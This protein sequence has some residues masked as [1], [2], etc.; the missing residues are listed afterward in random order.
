MSKSLTAFKPSRMTV[1]GSE[2]F[3]DS[4]DI[5]SYFGKRHDNVM[6]DI[7][8]TIQTIENAKILNSE[9]FKDAFFEQRTEF[10]PETNRRVTFYVLNKDAFSLLI[11]SYNGVKAMQFKLAYIAEFNRM[12]A[13]LQAIRDDKSSAFDRVCDDAGMILISDASKCTDLTLK[14]TTDIVVSNKWVYPRKRYGKRLAPLV[15]YSK[16][17]ADGFMTCKLTEYKKNGKTYRKSQACL[18]PKG[19]MEIQRQYITSLPGSEFITFE[20]AAQ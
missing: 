11:M 17:K 19:V 8:N 16:A 15:P 2:V 14:E 18:T 7:E 1:E 3:A 9:D 20:S 12:A 6:R 13:E 5:A 4:R 10:N